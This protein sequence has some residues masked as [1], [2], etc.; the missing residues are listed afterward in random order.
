MGVIADA[1]GVGNS[2]FIVGGTVVGLLFVIALL[3]HRSGAFAGGAGTGTE[4]P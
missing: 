3:V 2:F 1:V 4:A